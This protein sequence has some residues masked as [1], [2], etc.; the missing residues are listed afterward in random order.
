MGEEQ[1]VDGT[2]SYEK[3]LDIISWRTTNNWAYMR[4]AEYTYV[5]DNTFSLKTRWENVPTQYVAG[6]AST[7]DH[8][9][10]LFKSNELVYY[11]Q[12][13]NFKNDDFK[14]TISG[15]NLNIMRKNKKFVKLNKIDMA[16]PIA[17]W[18]DEIDKDTIR[19]LVQYDTADLHLFK[20]VKS[21][22]STEI[23]YK[24]R[25]VPSNPIK[26]SAQKEVEKAERL[27]A[28]EA[29]ATEVL[30]IEE[31]SKESTSA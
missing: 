23:N 22:A 3:T 7:A 17:G 9:T 21:A 5:Y 1:T 6:H 12:L 20:I 30:D 8:L 24:F 28:E 18:V 10:Y 25:V 31:S 27:A 15:K 4:I 13:D 26:S 16:D 2:C 19:L 14:M 29:A 11:R